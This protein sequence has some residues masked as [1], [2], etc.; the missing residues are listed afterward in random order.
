MPFS[1]PIIVVLLSL[2]FYGRSVHSRGCAVCQAWDAGVGGGH[3]HQE[4]AGECVDDSL[5][6]QSPVLPA[7]MGRWQAYE[8]T[9]EDF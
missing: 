2:S 5:L 9:G 6:L 4:A 7:R 1:A 3:W 8:D